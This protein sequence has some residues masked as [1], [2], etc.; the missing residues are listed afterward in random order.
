MGLALKSPGLRDT[1]FH[2]TAGR[3]YYSLSLPGIFKHLCH[4][5]TISKKQYFAGI[6]SNHSSVWWCDFTIPECR[7]TAGFRG[8]K[9]FPK[10]LQRSAHGVLRHCL[11][12]SDGA[13]LC[14]QNAECH[15]LKSH[16]VSGGAA[17]DSRGSS[18]GVAHVLP[19]GPAPILPGLSKS[20]VRRRGLCRGRP[21]FQDL[22][23]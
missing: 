19:R 7:A 8:I 18:L 10:G 1:S 21:D 3:Q 16:I 2:L 17:V 20:A 11:L 9:V 23:A 14:G 12:K 13:T 22:S 15:V 6:L 5:S 4:L